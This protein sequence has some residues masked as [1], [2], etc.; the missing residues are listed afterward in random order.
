MGG[1]SSL[2][3]DLLYVGGGVVGGIEGG[4]MLV[5]DLSGVVGGFEVFDFDLDDRRIFGR[6]MWRWIDRLTLN[7]NFTNF[8]LLG[9]DDV[10]LEGFGGSKFDVGRLWGVELAEWDIEKIGRC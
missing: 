2:S 3:K 7:L 5:L 8:Q 1:R 10:G 6:E 4:L 9:A